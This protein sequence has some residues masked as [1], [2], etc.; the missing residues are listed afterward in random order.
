MGIVDK[1]CDFLQ[2]TLFEFFA[3]LARADVIATNGNFSTVIVKN[4]CG[5]Y[6]ATGF[7]NK[8]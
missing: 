1:L 3:A 5:I 7:L 4:P 8:I 6:P 2:T